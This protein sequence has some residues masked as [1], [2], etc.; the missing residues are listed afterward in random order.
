[1]PLIS[2]K[3]IGAIKDSGKL[4]LSPVNVFCGKQGSG[5]STVAK[6]ISTFMWLEKALVRKEINAR[7]ITSEIFLQKYCGYHYIGSFFSKDSYV[8]YD[9]NACRFEYR[10]QSLTI[11]NKDIADYKIPQI[12]Y[13]PAERNFMIAVE[14]AEKI[15]NL[16]PALTTL[17]NE[18]LKALKN[19]PSYKISIN[20][21]NVE[22]DGNTKTTWLSDSDKYRIKTFEAASGLQ[23]FIPIAVVTEYLLEKIKKGGSKKLSAEENSKLNTEISNILDN[24]LLDENIRKILIENINRRFKNECLWNIVEEPEQNLF[25]E[26]QNKV[27]EILLSAYNRFDG[28]G[29]IITTHSPYIL[30]GL[31]LSAMAAEL[32]EKFFNSKEVLKKI[33]KIVP[34]SSIVSNQDLSIFEIKNNGTIKK[35]KSYSGIPSDDN[36]LNNYLEK[37]N[38]LFDELL[39]LEAEYDG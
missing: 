5:K 33:Y 13:I 37:S 35:L 17:Q 36:F 18:Y 1:M 38:D 20:G 19:A 7:E 14:N 25:P 26:S 6:L 9:G 2:I 30:N 11:E 8:F 28:N 22:Y 24:Q 32:K 3:N 29:L 10:D 15:S 27:L 12:M 23:S 31:S 34:E 4:L 39:G 16:P 21:Y